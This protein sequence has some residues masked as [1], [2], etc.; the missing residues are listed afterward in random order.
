MIIYNTES[1]TQKFVP[2]SENAEGITA[3]AASINKKV[4]AIAE[5]GEKATCTLYDVHT[6]RKRK[7]ISISES[8]AKV[9]FTIVNRIGICISCFLCGWQIFS[10]SNRIARLDFIIM[11]LGK[12][13]ITGINKG[14]TTYR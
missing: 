12:T 10:D 6:Q 8:E 11:G 2:C 3:M 5:R 7:T 1:K 4:V 9:E 13:K 14:G